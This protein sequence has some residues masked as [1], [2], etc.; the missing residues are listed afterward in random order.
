MIGSM[1]SQAVRRYD[2]KPLESSKV[3]DEADLHWL[4]KETQSRLDRFAG[5]VRECK[6][7]TE[8]ADFCRW[9]QFSGLSK[10]FRV[11]PQPPPFLVDHVIIEK[12][13]AD[14]LFECGE[15]FRAGKADP[16]YAASDI[17]EINRKLDVIAAHVSTLSPPKT[18]TP[19]V[20]GLVMPPA[21]SVMLG[22]AL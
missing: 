5:C 22:G 6:N 19:T 12:K 2:G 1:Q 16:N 20:D 3:I 21:L 7:V 17:A 18:Q 9:L 13:S 10:V 11:F 14:L 15:L 8:A 4:W